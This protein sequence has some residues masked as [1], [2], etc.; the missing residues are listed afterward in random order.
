VRF[1]TQC[2]SKMSIKVNGSRPTVI[3]AF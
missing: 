3:Y 1:E 2:T